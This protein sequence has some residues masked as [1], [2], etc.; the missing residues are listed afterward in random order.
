[1]ANSRKKVSVTTIPSVQSSFTRPM[2]PAKLHRGQEDPFLLRSSSSCLD[3]AE[4]A[5][6]AASESKVRRKKEETRMELEKIQ[7]RIHYTLTEYQ[8]P[9]VDEEEEQSTNEIDLHAVESPEELYKLLTD[10]RLRT[11]WQQHVTVLLLGHEAAVEDG[12]KL[13]QSIH[14]FFQETQ[15]G[16][17]A[18]L[19][20]EVASEEIDLDEATEGLE[21]A[22]RTAQTAGDRLLEIKRDMAQLFSIVKTFPDTKK[23]R[24]KMEKALLKAQEEVGSLQ[25]QLQGMQKELE[26]SKEKSG[27]L[28]KQI[29]SKTTECEKLRKTAAQVDQLQKT[30]A[31]LQSELV[32]A[33]EAAQKAKGDSEREKQ[34]RLSLLAKKDDVK[35]IVKVDSDQVQELQAALEREKEAMERLKAELDAKESEFHKEREA[36]VAEHEAEVQEMR[37]RYEEQMK[38]LVEDDLFSDTGGEEEREYEEREGDEE[39]DLGTGETEMDGQEDGLASKSAVEQLKMEY[40]QREKKLKEELKNKSRKTI[41]GLKVQLTEAENRHVDMCSGLQKQIDTLEREKKSNDAE[42]ESKEAQLAEAATREAEQ[43]SHITQL[44]REIVTLAA[45]MEGAGPDVASNLPQLVNRSAQW[46]E[47]HP[48]SSNSPPIPILP[49]DEVLYSYE[50]SADQLHPQAFP[51]GTPQSVLSQFPGGTPFSEG[52]QQIQFPGGFPASLDHSPASHLGSPLQ[53]F[54]AH[55][56]P[57]NALHM[58]AQSRLSH[59]SPQA[60]T[61]LSH[62]HPVVSEWIKAYDLVMKFR[63]GVVDMLCDDERFD[64]EVEDLRSIEG[65]VCVCMSYDRVI[66]LNYRGHHGARSG[67]SGSGDSDEVQSHPHAAS[68]GGMTCT[69]RW[70]V[71]IYFCCAIKFVVCRY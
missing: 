36:L 48:S 59:H 41:T 16:N 58:L 25:T 40:Q 1:M 43:Q 62:N 56:Q 15:A 68:D 51:G 21:S 54:S 13:L 32:K 47:H 20:E 18:Q 53:E 67:Y 44:Q 10:V 49:M 4:Q 55:A 69:F 37:S 61:T 28:Q 14:E 23:G 11:K 39:V 46:S 5:L 71:F 12:E 24:K 42:R 50:P 45:R 35:E 70:C 26:G 30:N 9:K 33:K 31:E 19:L 57:Q 65:E 52:S 27:R 3:P 60:A 7:E 63:D 6:L 38:S 34:E 2:S 17:T 64:N 22:L 29:D 66:T 8:G